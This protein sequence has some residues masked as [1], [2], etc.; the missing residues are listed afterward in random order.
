MTRSSTGTVHGKFPDGI[1]EG[2]FHKDPVHGKISLRFKGWAPIPANRRT[3]TVA[4]KRIPRDDDT[5]ED[6]VRRKLLKVWPTS[7]FERMDYEHHAAAP[8]PEPPP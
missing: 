4:R 8:E 6:A 5:A 2:R 3:Q 1:T 7:V